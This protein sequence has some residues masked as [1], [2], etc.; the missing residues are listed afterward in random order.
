MKIDIGNLTVVMPEMPTQS[1]ETIPI[2]E[3]GTIVM[4]QWKVSKGIRGVDG[5]YLVGVFDHILLNKSLWS[6]QGALNDSVSFI[7]NVA[8]N[9]GSNFSILSDEEV[10]IAN[11]KGRILT[12]SI[13]TSGHNRVWKT[14]V[15]VEKA[16]TSCTYV[17]FSITEKDSDVDALRMFSEIEP[18]TN[19]YLD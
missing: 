16:G 1:T 8:Q 9:L 3:I 10:L 12:G 11:L 6:A 7:L 15:L 18:Q 13:I 2:P 14:A 19:K 5:V 4:Q 17:F